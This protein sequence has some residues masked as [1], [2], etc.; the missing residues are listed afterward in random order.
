MI[1]IVGLDVFF[2]ILGMFV[3]LGFGGSL[4]LVAWMLENALTVGIILLILHIGFTVSR[5]VS[6]YSDYS[7]IGALCVAVH[8]LSLIHI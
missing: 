7:I 1:L 6:A 5:M 3:I 4:T 2:F 8:A